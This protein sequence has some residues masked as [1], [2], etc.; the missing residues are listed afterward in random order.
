MNGLLQAPSAT[1]FDAVASAA[2]LLVYLVVALVALARAPRDARART[3]LAV[4]LASAVPY[5]LSPLQWWKGNDIYTPS[6]IALTSAAFTVGS[7]ALFHFTQVFPHR[8][9]WI[10]AH[11]RWIVAAYLV[12]PPPVAVISRALDALLVAGSPAGGGI[13][14]AGAGGIGVVA[15]E[16]A[17]LLVVLLIPAILVVGVLLPCAG[18]L[19]LVKSWRDADGRAK[20]RES[21]LWML[22][23]Q[24]GGGVLSVLILP[25]LH[26]IGI[27]APWSVLIAALAYAFALLLPIAFARYPLIT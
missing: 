22:I 23:S 24:L 25:M 17:I 7:V 4:A 19:S 18:V 21:T 15:P 12:L 2:S 10:S 27:G 11:G 3:F 9:P 6:V 5:A 8:R 13:G 16:V 14:T 26:V 1:A 20:D